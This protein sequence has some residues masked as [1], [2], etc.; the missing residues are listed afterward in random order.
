M[1]RTIIIDDEPLATELVDELLKRYSDIEVVK[2]CHDGFTGLKAIQEH[3]PDLVFLDVQMPKL[4]GFEM[5]ELIDTPP[6]IIFCTAFDEYA[7]QAF[8][9][10]AV[11]YLLKPFGND[12]FAKA[13]EKMRKNIGEGTISSLSADLG[14]SDHQRIVVKVKNEI[15]II[16]TENVKYLEANDDFVNIHTGEGKFI[17]NKTLSYYEK[18]LPATEFVRVHRSYI[19]RIDHITKLEPYGKDSYIVKLKTGENIPISKTGLPKL[20]TALGI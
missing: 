17:K 9:A 1:I 11:D 6:A 16:P 18:N 4:T 20:K 12:R 8:D 3:Q 2:I 5:L 13:I 19:V 15:K 14:P 7:M 10:H